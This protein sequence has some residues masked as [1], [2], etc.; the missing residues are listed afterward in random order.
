M[1]VHASV[2][3]VDMYDTSTEYRPTF[4]DLFVESAGVHSTVGRIVSR[5]ELIRL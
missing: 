4:G 1:N 2:R 5:E 3:S